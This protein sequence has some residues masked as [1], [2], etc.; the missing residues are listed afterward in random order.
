MCS[1]AVISKTAVNDVAISTAKQHVGSRITAQFVS[2]EIGGDLIVAI[3]AKHSVVRV[4]TTEVRIVTEEAL[5]LA[6]KTDLLELIETTLVEVNA[7]MSTYIEDSE[8]S[9]LNRAPA[10]TPIQVSAAFLAVVNEAR[11]LRDL[12][13]GAFDVTVG[14]LVNAYGFGPTAGDL[15]GEDELEALRQR[16]GYKL[17]EIDSE[18]STLAKS[19]DDLYVDLSAL[20]KGYAVDRVAGLKIL[21]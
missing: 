13:D 20:A 8:I 16:T 18:A 4:Y 3:S 9:L 10:E 15:P 12:T 7:S 1:D 21:R 2:S 6:V 19:R 5:S 17:L 14:P 11:R